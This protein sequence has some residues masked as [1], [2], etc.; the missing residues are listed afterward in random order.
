MQTLGIPAEF[1][2]T[3]GAYKVRANL[4]AART[5]PALDDPGSARKTQQPELARGRPPTKESIP[6]MLQPIVSLAATTPVYVKVLHSD[7]D[8]LVGISDDV[9][10]V[11]FRDRTTV[12]GLNRIFRAFEDATRYRGRELA[13]LTII[14]SNARMPST[15]TREPIARWLREVSEKVLISAVVFE[16]DGFVAASVRSVVVGLTMLARQAYPHRVFPS[17]KEASEWFESEEPRLGKLFD[18]ISIQL[19]VARFRRAAELRR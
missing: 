9:F 4:P 5:W 11:V 19:A 15:G 13:L 1:P 12:E 14:Q 6:K 7:S 18:A 8:I 16:G 2:E 3:L 17:V 10:A